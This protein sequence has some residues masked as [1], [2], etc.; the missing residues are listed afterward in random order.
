MQ[1]GQ[2][3]A[4][5]D[6]TYRVRRDH[7][8]TLE[9]VNSTGYYEA[10]TDQVTPVL[11]PDGT[12]LTSDDWLVAERKK[13]MS[14]QAQRYT[15]IGTVEKFVT[16]QGLTYTYNNGL[17]TFHTEQGDHTFNWLDDQGRENTIHWLQERTATFAHHEEV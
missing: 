1:E 5:G 12:P 17:V 10:E 15:D 14:E 13:L 8:E 3:V 9:L 6:D 11:K 16:E 4:Y 7:G 2:I